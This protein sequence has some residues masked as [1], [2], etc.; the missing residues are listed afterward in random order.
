[1]T[2]EVKT[3]FQLCSLSRLEQ[4]TN[5]LPLLTCSTFSLIDHIVIIFPKRFSQQVII[6]MGL[7]DH[8]WIYCTRKISRTKVGTNKQITCCSLKICTAEA[9]KEP[10]IKVYFLNYEKSVD[11]NKAYET[12]SKKWWTSLIS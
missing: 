4:L 6:D 5:S 3:H 10:L 8:Q 2:H 7:S 11:V 12:S 1:M 9:Y